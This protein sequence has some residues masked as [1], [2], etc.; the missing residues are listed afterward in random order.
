MHDDVLYETPDVEE[1]L[2]R[3]PPKL[4]DDRN[5]RIIRAI[6]LSGTKKILPRAEWTKYE[7]VTADI[8][9]S[10]KLVFT[11]TVASVGCSLPPAIP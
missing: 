7:E 1:A 9:Y 5:F 11:L 8:L 4:L 3:L 2:R 10:L 6:N